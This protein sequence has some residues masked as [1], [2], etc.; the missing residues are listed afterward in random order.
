LRIDP[1]PYVSGALVSGASAHVIDRV[2]R[3]PNVQQVLDN[4][5]EWLRV[6]VEATVKAIRRAAADYEALPISL[7]RSAEAPVGEIAARSQHIGSDGWLDVEQAATLLDVTP[8]RVQQ[9]AA[10]GMGRRVGRI[11]RLDE[12]AV[13]AYGQR[14]QMG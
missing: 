10:G 7:R 4:L 9:L 3:S 1:P 14:R 11:W 8:R 13:R 6:E 12:T 5:P 2:L